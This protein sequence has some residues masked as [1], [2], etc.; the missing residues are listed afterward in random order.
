MDDAVEEVK[1]ERQRLEELAEHWTER[2]RKEE[3][4]HGDFRKSAEKASKA[5]KN[6]SKQ[7]FNILWSNVQIQKGAVYSNSPKAE[8]RRRT[9]DVNG[10]DAQ[11]T[12]AQVVERALDYVVDSTNFDTNY[13]RCVQDYLTTALGVPRVRYSPSFGPKVIGEGEFRQEVEAITDQKLWVE[14]MPWSS[15]RWMP[16][17]S[18][19]H[20][21]WI[22]FEFSKPKDWVKEKYDLKAEDDLD[23]ENGHKEVK[24]IEIYDRKTKTI[25]TLCDQF[26]VP[27]EVREDKLGL[28]DFYPVPKVLMA[29]LAEQLTPKP[30][31]E[32]YAQDAEQ[33]NRLTTRIDKLIT[34]VK[35]VGFYDAYLKELQMLEKK[36][37]GSMVPIQ[38]LMEK[39]GDNPDLNRAIAKLPIEQTVAVIV[40]LRQEQEELKQQIYEVI[41]L[42]D[43]MRGASKATE[44]A[45]AQGIKAQFGSIRLS[46]KQK[47]V[48][49]GVR[50]I[51]RIMAEI[52]GEH[53]Q[54][55]VLSLMTGIQVDESVMQ[56]LRNDV[57][58]NFSIDVETESTI[59][60]DEQAERGQR[61]EALK[62]MNDY[63]VNILPAMSNG[64][65]PFEVGKELL[66]MAVR[67]HKF[68]GNLEDVITN[69]TQENV[70]AQLQQQVAQMGEQIEQLRQQA[71]QANQV[72]MAGK[73]ADIG[74]THAETRKTNAEATEQD[75]ENAANVQALGAGGPM[76]AIG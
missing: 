63:L 59:A 39:L 74:K 56:I 64:A 67:G 52:I 24:L 16:C 40:S 57:L 65:I 55:D 47:A 62:I 17:R 35:D 53:Y 60:R 42:S 20:C 3:T 21:G 25:V 51:F 32:Y 76:V 26:K 10:Q 7:R 71:S 29:N 12:A 48:A 5:F 54:P 15:F 72:D 27:V 46:D 1:D 73:A 44:T 23:V 50:D 31:Y 22:A 18:W 58:R 28:Q 49:F 13:G 14:Y 38:D 2:L 9:K 8:V 11:K 34:A 69:M 36:P 30:D 70:I 45:E 75:I 68:V 61:M 43:I 4:A 19:E 41:G 66:L 33:L 6:K 37:D